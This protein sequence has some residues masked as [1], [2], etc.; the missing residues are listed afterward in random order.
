MEQIDAAADYCYLTT[1]GRVTGKPHV[2]EI[3]FGTE[4]GATLF[5]LA[6]SGRKADFVRN[7]MK[8]PDVTLRIGTRTSALRSA[9]ARIVTDAGEDALARRLLLAKYVD[10]GENLEEWGRTALPVAFDL[11]PT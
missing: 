2:I 10:R 4:D 8:A 5:V 9:T 6:G 3:W 1:T 7:A 11:E